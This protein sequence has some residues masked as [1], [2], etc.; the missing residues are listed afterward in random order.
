MQDSSEASVL[1]EHQIGD[2]PLTS[3]QVRLCITFFVRLFIAFS[4]L[5][6]SLCTFMYRFDICYFMQASIQPVVLEEHQSEVVGDQP[7]PPCQVHVCFTFFENII[8][9]P[10]S[11]YVFDSFYYMKLTYVTLYRLLVR[12]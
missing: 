1:E 11:L 8:F 9:R 6:L 3:Q 7:L 5:V 12:H 4:D 2:P 10:C